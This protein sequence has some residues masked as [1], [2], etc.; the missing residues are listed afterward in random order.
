M[1]SRLDPDHSKAAANRSRKI[2]GSRRLAL[3]LLIGGLLL[4]GCQC[5]GA[6]SFDRDQV[7]AE[8]REAMRQFEAQEKERSVDGLLSFLDPEFGM[9]QD[10]Q[11][12]GHAATVDQMKMSLPSLRSFEPRFDDIEI[13]ALT[14]D[15]AL[16]SMVFHDVITA[17]DGSVTRM[18]GPS[19]LLWRRSND[20]KWRILFA[21]SDHYP[22][23][24]DR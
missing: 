18:W 16:T 19:T 7:I 4:G 1:T 8:V 6:G 20:G 22:E 14:E 24:E 11:R 23:P 15:L 21:D 13:R 2:P 3:L 9:L 10:G 17:G 5:P 12:V